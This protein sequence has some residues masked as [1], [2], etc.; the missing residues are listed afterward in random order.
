MEDVI[1]QGHY[2]PETTHNLVLTDAGGTQI[3]PNAEAKVTTYDASPDD[4]KRCDLHPNDGD[5]STCECEYPVPKSLEEALSGNMTFV[6]QGRGAVK[7]GPNEKV[8][9]QVRKGVQWDEHSPFLVAR[10][11]ASIVPAHSDI[12]TPRFVTFLAGYIHEFLKEAET[13]KPSSNVATPSTSP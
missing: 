7:T 5:F 8:A 4:I 13:H 6:S 9:L 3:Y 1:G 12:Y 10:V 11:S 2:D